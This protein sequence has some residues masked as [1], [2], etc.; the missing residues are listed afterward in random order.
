MQPGVL[1]LQGRNLH[2]MLAA[3]GDDPLGPWVTDHQRHLQ[4]MASFITYSAVHWRL[5]LEQCF[6]HSSDVQGW[7]MRSTLLEMPSVCIA[8]ICS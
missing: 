6:D 4:T 3:Q 7:Q 5:A 2:C 8:L 1:L